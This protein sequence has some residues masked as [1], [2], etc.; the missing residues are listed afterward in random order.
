MPCRGAPAIVCHRLFIMARH[1]CHARTRDS[2]GHDRRPRRDLTRLH[3]P[4]ATEEPAREERDEQA[5]TG[6][7]PENT[8]FSFVEVS[9]SRFLS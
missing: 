4:P 7:P 5:Y 3:E 8:W 6:R 9:H 2:P 1:R